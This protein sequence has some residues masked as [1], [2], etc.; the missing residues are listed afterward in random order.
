M[1]FLDQ[2]GPTAVGKDL[3]YYFFKENL[4]LFKLNI[5]VFIEN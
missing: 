5:S 3:K 1:Y 2:F 4:Y